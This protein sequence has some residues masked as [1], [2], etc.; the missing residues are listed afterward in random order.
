MSIALGQRQGLA[1]VSAHS[2]PDRGSGGGGGGEAGGGLVTISQVQFQA[3]PVS[4][5]NLRGGK[6]IQYRI[7]LYPSK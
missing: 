5:G 4:P 2:P 7:R 1:R 6:H 3:L